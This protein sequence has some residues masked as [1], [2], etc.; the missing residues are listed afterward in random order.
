MCYCETNSLYC[1][2]NKHIMK[3][4]NKK[5]EFKT[6]CSKCSNDLEANRVGKARYC[7]SCHNDYMKTNRKK[8]SE[9]TEEQKL[10]ANCRSYLNVYLKRGKIIKGNCIKCN[11]T[12]K[13]EAHHHD[14]TKPLDVIWLCR[15]CHLNE[16]KLFTINL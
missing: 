9:L 1:I 11:S 6:T 15:I 16:H 4:N 12:E 14:Y 3:Q 5:R 2:E 13:V 8:H 10:K 7:L